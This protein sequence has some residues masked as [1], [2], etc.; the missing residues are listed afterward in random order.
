[1]ARD[2]ANDSKVKTKANPLSARFKDRGE[3]VLTGFQ[4]RPWLDSDDIAIHR[5]DIE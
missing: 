2:A 4:I 3:S 1:L 5:L